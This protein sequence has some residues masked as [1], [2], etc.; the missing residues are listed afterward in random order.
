[1]V[2]STWATRIV[3][4]AAAAVIG[5]GG[6]VAFGG[7]GPAQYPIPTVAGSCLSA[8]TGDPDG[9][10]PWGGCWP[11]PLSTGVTNEGALTTVGSTVQLN[12]D[13]QTYENKTV[14][15]CI[16]IRE[17][18]I[19]LRNLRVNMPS[20]GTCTI[21]LCNVPESCGAA[22]GGS[23]TNL[24]VEDV[25]VN[26]GT[27]DL[28]GRGA[29]GGGGTYR[30]VY[31]HGNCTNT[32]GSL[33]NPSLV[34][35]SF[36]DEPQV[37]VPATDPHTDAFEVP[38]TSNVTILHNLIYGEYT[39]ATHF[40]SGSVNVGG[41]TYTNVIVK[42]NIIAGGGYSVYCPTN[43]AAGFTLIENHFSTHFTSLVG[44]YGPSSGCSGFDGGG[45]VYHETGLP[46]TLG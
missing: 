18:N 39:D 15:G 45:N 23:N 8:I 17:D 4:V 37:Y 22:D 30:R 19:T 24:L 36:I 31:F 29:S 38:N 9:P 12:T 3:T 5:V 1:M 21:G 20:D 43:P 44:G 6:V 33:D 46:V 41:S 35:N 11:G 34:E 32:V 14:T 40:G 7:K 26:C 10:D 28:A 13:G 16:E 42:R 2:G 25:E 27:T